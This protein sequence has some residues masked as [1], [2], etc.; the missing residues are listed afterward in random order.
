[1]KLLGGGLQHPKDCEVLAVCS[2]WSAHRSNESGTESESGPGIGPWSVATAGDFGVWVWDTRSAGEGPAIKIG[3]RQEEGPA[4]SATIAPDALAGDAAVSTA[5]EDM[6]AGSKG[7]CCTAVCF[8]PKE[9]YTVI[10]AD[11]K[12]LRWYD[13]RAPHVAMTQ[14]SVGDDE[15][16]QISVNDRGSHLACVSALH[17]HVVFQANSSASSPLL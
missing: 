11:E 1:M 7:D 3:G 5:A 13:L 2:Q 8:H 16:N 14:V 17:E 15:I 10:A 4:K 6:V 9:E 12:A